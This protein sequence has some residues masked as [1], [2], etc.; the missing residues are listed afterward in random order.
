MTTESAPK[1]ASG[2]LEPLR[3]P[4]FR[5]LWIANVA[6]NIGQMIAGVGAAWTMTELAGRADMVALVQT[7][8]LAPVMLLALPAGAVADMFDRRK[9]AL[10][11]LSLA[12]AGATVMSVLAGLQMLNPALILALTFLM[13]SAMAVYNPSW[14]AS[15]SGQVPSSQV[16]AAIALKTVGFNVARSIG[17]AIG[18]LVVVLAGPTPAFALNALLLVP[19]MVVFWRWRQVAESPRLPPERLGGAII[20]GVRYVANSPAI[21]GVLCRTLITAVLGGSLYGLLPLIARDLPGGDASTYGLLLGSFGVG[22][23]TGAVASTRL[24]TL[25]SSESMVRFMAITTAAALGVMAISNI[26]LLTQLALLLAGAAWMIGTTTFNVSVQVAAPRW[27]AGRAVAMFQAAMAGGLAIGS[28]VWGMLAQ[29]LG[30]ETALLISGVSLALSTV[31]G[32]WLPLPLRARPAVE[33]ETLPEPDVGMA[34]TPRSGPIQVEIEYRVPRPKARAF[35][36][37][38]QQVGF[39]RRRNGAYD[40]SLARDIAEPEVWVE[41]YSCPTWLD[42]LRQRSRTTQ[43]ERDLHQRAREF[44][45]EDQPIRIRRRLERPFGSVRWR[46]D[47]PDRGFDVA[48]LSGPGA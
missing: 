8:Q 1:P 10:V 32:L 22:A 18:G 15:V 7:A 28:G 30:H 3:E 42:Y 24:R 39:G 35:W 27:V 13:G 16:A 5:R 29:A 37:F 31:I 23:I 4:A 25:F 2:A 21:R 19:L 46:D 47:A 26:L 20:A 12:L 36:L 11:S 9:V 43:A 33:A 45:V 48:P 41:S 40:W 38:M 44:Q 34:L 17:P 14:Q 6:S